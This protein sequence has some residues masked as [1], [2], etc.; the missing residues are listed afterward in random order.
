MAKLTQIIPA[1][2]FETVGTRIGLV[3]ATELDYQQELN[4]NADTSPTV[5]KDRAVPFNYEELPAINICLATGE[6][7]NK[8]QTQADG[9]YSYMVDIYAK[10]ASTLDEEADT[11]EHG[12]KLAYSHLQRMI[13]MCR[14]ILENPQYRTLDFTPPSL[15]RVM[16][17]GFEIGDIKPEDANYSVRARLRFEVHVPEY[18]ELKEGLP[19]TSHYTNILLHDT[20]KGYRYVWSTQ[21]VVFANQAGTGFTLPPQ[22]AHYRQICYRCR[23]GKYVTGC[24][25]DKR[26]CISVQYGIAAARCHG[27][28]PGKREH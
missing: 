8:D 11:I 4:P 26:Y 14:A 17:Q 13:A 24:S 1:A 6:Y 20:D 19:L 12:D 18:V 25:G 27:I 28:T 2:N 15:K 16:V 9:A 10:A 22:Y 23:Y 5:W 7:S 3:L 21:A